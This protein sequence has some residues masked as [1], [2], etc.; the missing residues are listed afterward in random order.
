MQNQFS[1]V[2]RKPESSSTKPTRSNVNSIEETTTEQSVKAIQK[3]N[4]NPRCESDYD[5]SYDNMVASIASTTVQIE[6]KNAILQIG[7]TKVGLLIESGSVCS[8][9]NESL[10]TEVISNS[11]LAQWL[12]K[13]PPQE[14]KTF[15]NEPIPVMGIM[16]APAESKGSRIEDAEFVVLRDGLKP[17]I[18]RDLFA[19]LGISITQTLCSDESSMVNTITTQCPFKTSIA[20]QFPHFISRIGRSKVRIVE[21]KFHKNFQSKHQK[22]R[23]VPINLQERVNSE[24]KKLLEKKHI[25]KFNNCSDQNFISPI[26][27]TVERDQTINLALD[28]KSPNKTVHKNKYQM[29]NNETLIDSLSQIITDYKTESADKIYFSTIDLKYAYSQ[30]NLHPDTAK[31]CNFNIVSGDMTGTYRFKTGFYGLTD[32]P[33]EIQKTMDHKL[34]G[35]KSTFCFLDNSFIV[36]K[37]SEEDHIQ[38]VTDC[39]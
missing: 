27:I 11:T 31:H 25:E 39:L 9:L 29:P 16:Q 18:G 2:C 35:L 12:T 28:S 34:I 30:L 17:L 4:Y 20:N 15:A 36:S 24:T 21:S 22:S 8:I 26:V 6:H 37:G 13:T 14:L 5:S 7:I 33:A 23:K 1:R 38:L 10:A 32:N 3:T 19:D